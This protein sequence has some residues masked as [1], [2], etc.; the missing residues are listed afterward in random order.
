MRAACRAR[1]SASPVNTALPLFSS[2]ATSR[3]AEL[4]EQRAQVRHG[5]ALRL[6]DVDAAEQRDVARHVSLRP[7]LPQSKLPTLKP[8]AS[9]DCMT[10]VAASKRVCLSR[11][12]ST[13]GFDVG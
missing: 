3:V 13:R 6:A 5:D 10:S 12:M 2:V 11:Q 4:A 1:G 8:A 9:T 7:V